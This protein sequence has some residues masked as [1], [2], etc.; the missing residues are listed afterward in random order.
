[1][2]QVK[3]AGPSPAPPFVLM[4]MVQDKPENAMEVLKFFNW[5]YKNGSKM[6]ESLDYVPMP[7]SVVKLIEA[8]WKAQIKDTA[9]KPVWK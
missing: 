5:S 8:A 9:G 4:H 1:M 2:S 6:A 3:T 7:L